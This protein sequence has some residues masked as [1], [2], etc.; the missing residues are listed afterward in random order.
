MTNTR[1]NEGAAWE[2]IK[3]LTGKETVKRQIL[4]DTEGV[5]GR[6]DVL[7]DPEVQQKLN[8]EYLAAVKK[9]LNHGDPEY[10]PL[11]PQG[12]QIREILAIQL[13]EALTGQKSP[14]E[15]IL[16]ANEKV[17]ATLAE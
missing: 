7:D 17:K 10:S 15:A 12:P 13:S 11:I 1:Q 5:S 14:K 6:T 2:Y 16:E 9:A 4:A 3:W 8:P